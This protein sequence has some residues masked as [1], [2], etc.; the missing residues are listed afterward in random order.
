[1]E[2]KKRKERKE[3]LDKYCGEEKEKEKKVSSW[4]N[5]VERKKRE[6][7]KGKLHKYCGKEEEKGEK[8]KDV[9]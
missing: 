3:Y 2:R 4:I 6:E 5:T 9:G 8:M 1:M 7:R